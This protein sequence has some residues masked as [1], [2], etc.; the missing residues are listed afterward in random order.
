[1]R[2]GQKPRQQQRCSPKICI[3]K[4]KEIKIKEKKE[5]EKK[6]KG[7]KKKERKKVARGREKRGREKGYTSAKID[8][9][10][11]QQRKRAGTADFEIDI[12]H[13][14]G[15]EH[16]HRHALEAVFVTGHFFYC[17]CA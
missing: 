10:F 15:V 16:E 7:K 14:D 12:R 5:K 17:P 3:K 11:R 6:E 2:Q 9:A 4:I 1:V 13:V 8:I